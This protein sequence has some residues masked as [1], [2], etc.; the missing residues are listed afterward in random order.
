MGARR[1][2]LLWRTWISGASSGI[3]EA[4]ARELA[5]RGC[6]LALFARREAELVRIRGEILARR[7]DAE[8]LVQPGDVTDRR[9]VGE[10]IRAA[11]AAFGGLDVV[12]LNAGTGDS[13]FPDRFDAG[14]VE[15]IT[16]VNYLGAV[17]A[18]E[19]ALPGMLARREG[20]IAGMSSI[21]AVRGL[22]GA[23][24]YC[25]SKAALSTFLES[26]RVDLRGRGVGVTTVSPG[27]VRTP[28]TDRNR[29]PMPFI[30]PADR[31]ARR[32]VEG[33]RRGRREVCFPRRLTIPAR[34]LRFLPAGLYDWL[35][36][37]AARKGYS[38]APEGGG[39]G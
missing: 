15:R 34:C 37:F 21:S 10:A 36:S 26:L 9:R 11:E 28:L 4:L 33:I 8:V 32:I 23:G 30:Q 13:L 18:I 12:I 35:M 27:F 39:E 20:R 22:P 29:F 7:P 17:Y 19:A 14:L 16:R 5:A 2:P 38:K 3:G 31:A 24:P 6:R 25:A 1:S